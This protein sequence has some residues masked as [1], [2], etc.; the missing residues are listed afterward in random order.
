MRSEMVVNRHTTVM[1]SN[2]TST[3]YP[4]MLQKSQYRMKVKD[5]FSTESN[6]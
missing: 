6:T 2:D 3:K 5:A 4:D 1:K